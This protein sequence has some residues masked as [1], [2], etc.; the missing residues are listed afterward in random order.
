MRTVVATADAITIKKQSAALYKEII[1]KS[2]FLS[3][4]MGGE[5]SLKPINLLT[6][7]EKDAGD[8]I[9]YDLFMKIKGKGVEGDDLLRGKE[10]K[11]VWYTDTVLINQLRHGVDTGGKMSRKRTKHNLRNIARDRLA[12]WWAERWDELIMVYM[13]GAR[14]VDTTVYVLDS[15][16]SSFAGNS[17]AAPD[18]DHILYGGDAT[19]KASVDANDKFT[20]KAIDKAVAK[21]NMLRPQIQPCTVDGDEP[22]FCMLLHEWQVFDLRTD[23]STGQ[24]LDI[25]KAAATKDGQKNPIFSGAL[26]VYNNVVLHRHPKVPRFTDY[27]AGSNIA[28]ARALF[29]GA[30]ACVV[31]FGSP[32]DGLRFSWHE[33]MEDRGNVLVVDTGSIFGIKKCTFNSKDYGV[34]AVDTAAAQPY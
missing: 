24:W 29:M 18:S 12:G 21:A 15:A 7:L 25:Q 22:H 6:D 26:G 10:E 1:P 8:S 3:K 4:F 14:G 31:A 33:E 17:L 30:Q 5:G 32:G 23:T 20:M 13:A 9:S 11:L 16:F 28:A 19:S 34:I 2:F 27:G